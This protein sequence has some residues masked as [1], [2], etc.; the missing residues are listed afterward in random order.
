MLS[1][2]RLKGEERHAPS[3]D[4]ITFPSRVVQVTGTP[5]SACFASVKQV[6]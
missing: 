2:A 6:F 1:F 3:K 5:Y 4:N